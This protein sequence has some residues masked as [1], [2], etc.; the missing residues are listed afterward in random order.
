M[1]LAAGATM[2]LLVAPRGLRSVIPRKLFDYLAAKRPIFAVSD[3]NEITRMLQGTSAGVW[4][5]ADPGTI[6][7]KLLDLFHLWRAGGLDREIPCAG[8]DL[9]RA[10]PL[11]ERVLGSVV[12]SELSHLNPA[13]HTG[14][15]SKRAIQ[16]LNPEPRT[17][18]PE[19]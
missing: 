13:P 10:A 5:P 3:E 16:T 14:P 18:N 7:Q 11:F 17:L 12:L 9:Y 6:A 15:Q 19:P 8:N 2:L 4:C 1:R